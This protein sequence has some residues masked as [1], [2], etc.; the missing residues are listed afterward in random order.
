MLNGS[1][2][3]RVGESISTAEKAMGLDSLL[4]DCT[5]ESDAWEAAEDADVHVVHTHY[6][7]SFR[8][9]EKKPRKLVWV[10]H[11]TPDH[12]FQS[13]VEAGLGAPYGHADPF[14]LMQYWLRNA[15]ARVTFWPRHQW[16]YQRLVDRGTPIHCVPLGVD[17]A[18][19]AA[20]VS[21]GKY[22]GTPSVFY[23]ENQHY[24]KWSYDI[25]IA[26]PEIA[27]Q[28]KG[29]VL[30]N[31][32]VPRDMH[33]WVF[34]L[35][36]ANGASYSS[37]ISPSTYAHDELRNVFRSVDFQLGLVRYGDFNQLSLQANAAGTTTISYAGNPY[38]DY[39]IREGDQR[40]I[41]KDLSAILSGEVPK[42]VKTPVP[43]ITETAQAMV[44]IYETLVERVAVAA[45]ELPAAQP[46]P[47]KS[48][49]RSHL[50]VA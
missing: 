33:R 48:R 6:P 2:M 10:A 30:H 43:D 20:G 26:W 41:A 21:R 9:R 37:H 34:P 23:A 45:P 13:S 44:A 36:N 39:W 31:I 42:R 50:K 14:M 12:V 11:G 40:G 32:Y 38:A 29:A 47:R 15:D 16:I 22:S 18:F 35:V 1:G 28:V 7:D 46:K 27:E 49:K 3:H 24:I 17:T 5:S 19:W 8:G 25:L 4:V